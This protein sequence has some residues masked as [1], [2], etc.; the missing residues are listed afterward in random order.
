[1]T[2]CPSCLSHIACVQKLSDAGFIFIQRN[3][4]MW[5]SEVMLRPSL[6]GEAALEALEQLEDGRGTIN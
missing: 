6:A 3:D 5:K 2:I 4:D 1:M